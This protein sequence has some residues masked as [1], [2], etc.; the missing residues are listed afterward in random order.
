MIAPSEG[1]SCSPFLTRHI[2]LAEVVEDHFKIGLNM[3]QLKDLLEFS[4]ISKLK[5]LFRHE[6][7]MSFRFCCG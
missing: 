6:D 5:L 1:D 7:E 4:C 3:K 2:S